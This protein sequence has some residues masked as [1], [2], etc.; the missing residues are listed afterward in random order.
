MRRLEWHASAP[1]VHLASTIDRLWGL[2]PPYKALVTYSCDTR[3]PLRGCYHT[4]NSLHI[5]AFAQQSR[6]GAILREGFTV[7]SWIEFLQVTF[8]ILFGLSA[9]VGLLALLS[10][11][12]LAKVASYGN[13]SIY[14]GTE[15]QFDGR[16]VDVDEFVVSHGRLF[17]GCV[18]G[19]IGYLTFIS[20]YGPEEYTKSSLLM[21]VTVAMGM[22]G[23]ALWH[24]RRQSQTIAVCRAEAHTDALTGLTNRR[25]L[26]T[27]I[28]RRLAQQQRQGTPLSL[29]IIDIDK[30]KSFNDCFGHVLGDKVLKRVAEMLLEVTRRMDT[31]ARLGG[32]EFVVLL[33]DCPLDAATETAER[34][35]SAIAES[36]LSHEGREHAPTVSIGVCEAQS[37]DDSI[38]LIKRADSALYAAKD[39]GRNCCFRHG[40]PERATPVS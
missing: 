23:V 29:L 24:I 37:D 13:R 40:G 8:A 11:T 31:V 14:R 26:E 2:H 35:R 16:W 17:G 39:A 10:P 38:S 15:T 27:E 22:G 7:Q 30:F 12:A 20:Y 32:D 36:P 28:S 33:P 3:Q 21:V 6:R 34:C 25:V 1:G 5:D 4:T 18:L 19:I 9:C